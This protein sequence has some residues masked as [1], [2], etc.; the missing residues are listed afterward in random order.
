MSSCHLLKTDCV[1]LT[2]NHYSSF[3]YRTRR[4]L[5]EQRVRIVN[6]LD[7]V[8]LWAYSEAETPFC[9]IEELVY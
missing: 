1:P 8:M 7:I 9:G 2:S 6:G 3:L 4:C 5:A